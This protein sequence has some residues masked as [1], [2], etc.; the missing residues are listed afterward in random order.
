[1]KGDKER[2]ILNEGEEECERKKD[3]EVG[4][5]IHGELEGI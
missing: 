3:G 1:M 4:R 2:W 5:L